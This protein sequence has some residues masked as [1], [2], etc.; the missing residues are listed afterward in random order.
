MQL[1]AMQALPC[2]PGCN[3]NTLQRNLEVKGVGRNPVTSNAMPPGTTN[4]NMPEHDC[5]AQRRNEA[6]IA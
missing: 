6:M 4:S 1:H 2:L 3:E 5:Q